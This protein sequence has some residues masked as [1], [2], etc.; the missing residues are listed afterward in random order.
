MAFEN[1]N[2]GSSIGVTGKYSSKV[3]IGASLSY[4]DD[5]SAYAQ[6][7]DAA[8]L[9]NVVNQL[10]LSGGLPDINYRQ[11]ALKL[12][13]N[14]TLEKKSSVRVDL[15]HQRTSINDWTWGYNGVPF[16][17]SDSATVSQNANQNVSY[18]GVTYVYQL[19]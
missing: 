17:Y 9:P 13:A 18:I 5:R 14:Y 1:N 11:T 15:V 10:A 8:A 6:S 3:N 7:P 4:V 19:P 16:S 2:M 12:F